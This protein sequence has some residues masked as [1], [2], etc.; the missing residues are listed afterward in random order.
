M[1]STDRLVPRYTPGFQTLARDKGFIMWRYRLGRSLQ[2]LGLLILPFAMASELMEKVGL[3]Q[4]LLL[5]AA[6]AGVFYAGFQ[7]QHRA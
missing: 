3:G 2:F 7:I 6:G 4:S 1:P 5:A